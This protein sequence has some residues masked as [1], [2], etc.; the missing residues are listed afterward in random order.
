LY[1]G[2]RVELFCEKLASGKAENEKSVVFLGGTMQT[3]KKLLL[4]G[5]AASVFIHSC[6]AIADHHPFH[7]AKTAK[8]GPSD[9]GKGRPK[10]DFL[11]QAERDVADAQAELQ[12][13]RQDLARLQEQENLLRQASIAKTGSWVEPGDWWRRKEALQQI[14]SARQQ[15][16]ERAKKKLKLAE[17]ESN[18]SVD[19][20]SNNRKP[21]WFR[22][23]WKR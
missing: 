19:T 21:S 4:A 14:L 23:W 3:L 6:D 5:L 20:R 18:S 8:P 11:I 22:S 17:T 15:A 7:R 1:S 12:T 10:P 16:T 2:R 13:A 9:Q